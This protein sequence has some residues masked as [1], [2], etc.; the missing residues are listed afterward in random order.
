MSPTPT[1][2]VGLVC[3]ALA[4]LAFR[5]AAAAPA[6]T[7]N[8]D[9]EAGQPEADGGARHDLDAYLFSGDVNELAACAGTSSPVVLAVADGVDLPG[10]VPL[11][12]SGSSPNSA[13]GD[14]NHPG[15]GERAVALQCMP[16]GA[17]EVEGGQCAGVGLLA[18][19][20]QE[21]SSS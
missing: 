8:G 20:V 21:K 17:A 2:I 12:G 13:E 11:L 9:E 5:R 16:V 15:S 4:P 19:L 7:A 6:R 10:G 18:Y 3:V 1:K 14:G